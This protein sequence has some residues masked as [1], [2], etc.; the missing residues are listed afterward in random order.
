VYFSTLINGHVTALHPNSDAQMSCAKMSRR[1]NGKHPNGGAQM[2]CS[3]QTYFTLKQV[4]IPP[5]VPHYNV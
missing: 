3:R 1:S 4:K 2:S 5:T